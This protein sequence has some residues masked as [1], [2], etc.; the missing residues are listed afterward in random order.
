MW[1]TDL[2]ISL[3]GWLRFWKRIKN[4]GE[5]MKAAVV[6]SLQI[7]WPVCLGICGVSL[8]SR[9]LSV[10]LCPKWGAKFE[11]LK[12]KGRQKNVQQYRR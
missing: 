1:Y 3:S 10:Y 4:K 6:R 11:L 12:G 9:P 5:I 8:I 7:S 2:R